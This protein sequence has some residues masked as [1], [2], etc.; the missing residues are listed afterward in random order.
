MASV[1]DNLAN[2]KREITA[3]AVQYHR[4]PSKIALLA[5]SK[6]QPIEKII[7]AYEAGQR[8]FG[9]NFLQE[10]LKKI[11]FLS[12]Y[13]IEWHFIGNIQANKTRKIAENFTWVQSVSRMKIAERLNAQR[14]NGLPPLNICI[15]VNVSEESTK[16]GIL[17]H[18]VISLAAI[19]DKMEN[20]Q[21]RGLMAIPMATS[22]QAQQKL[23]FKKVYDLQQELIHRGYKLDTLSLGMS[24][25]FKM[26]IAQGSTMVRIGSALFGQREET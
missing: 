17:P 25:D 7:A 20:L 24:Q 26:A 16:S 22:D 5:V 4:D 9:E 12:D 14:P 19:I 18:Q 10:A 11:T 21:L 1:A 6:Q 8:K 15:E 2:I 23:L 13:D 3:T